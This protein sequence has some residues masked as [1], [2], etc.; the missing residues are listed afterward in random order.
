MGACAFQDCRQLKRV[1]F[2]EPSRLEEIPEYC[3]ANMGL[4]EIR[5]P[6]S[7]KAIRAKAFYKCFRLRK[8]SFAADSALE[9]IAHECFQSSGLEAIVLPPRVRAVQSAAFYCCERLKIVM[10]NPGLETIG[11]QNWTKGAFSHT[12][13]E[14]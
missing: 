6:A 8:V 7:V 9:M 12:P 5:V 2:A 4:T 14:K 10:L 13:L 1:V 11:D 3:F